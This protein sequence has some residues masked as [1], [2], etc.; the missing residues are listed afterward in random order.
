[1]LGN[2]E[3]SPSL[4]ENNNSTCTNAAILSEGEP[5]QTNLCGRC[6]R[7]V[8][9]TMVSWA[10]MTSET[11]RDERPQ[12]SQVPVETRPTIFYLNG[13][14][15]S[16]WESWKTVSV[17]EVYGHLCLTV[18]FCSLSWCYSSAQLN[19]KYNKKYS[20][21][22]DKSEPAE[23]SSCYNLS[24]DLLEVCLYK[25][26][27]KHESACTSEPQTGRI[28][29]CINSSEQKW[30]NVPFIVWLHSAEYIQKTLGVD[31]KVVI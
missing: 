31:A 11:C 6:E 27:S 5:K 16:L 8:G 17:S 15:I 22:V 9:V 13:S 2:F 19:L 20:T 24:P 3:K 14:F 25:N 23:E 18:G 30:S 26:T 21:T 10:F 1:M 28:Q 29:N 4:S 7:W 12:L